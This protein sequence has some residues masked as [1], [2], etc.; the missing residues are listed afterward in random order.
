MALSVTVGNRT[1]VEIEDIFYGS[2][3]FGAPLLQFDENENIIGIGFNVDDYDN[4]YR[5]T[6]YED[7]FTLYSPCRGRFYQ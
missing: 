7:G 1:F 5:L 4:D 3:I 6:C 2:G